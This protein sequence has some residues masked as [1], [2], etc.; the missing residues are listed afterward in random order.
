MSTNVVLYILYLFNQSSNIYIYI[1]IY[2]YICTTPCQPKQYYIEGSGPEWCI[3]SML[4]SRDTPFWLGTLDIFYTLSTKV[5]WGSSFRWE[6]LNPVTLLCTTKCKPAIL[7][8]DVL[9]V[10][11]C[12]IWPGTLLHV[13]TSQ[14]RV[15]ERVERGSW[16]CLLVA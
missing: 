1:Y 16:C 8:T 7:E 14:H 12:R 2:I 15:G 6:Y 13:L 11:G 9:H 3:S 10:R 4:C 5:R